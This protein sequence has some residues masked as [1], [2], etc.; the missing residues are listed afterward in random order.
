M[1]DPR[2]SSCS[3]FIRPFEGHVSRLANAPASLPV[4][5]QAHETSPEHLQPDLDSALS[6]LAPEWP[7]WPPK[8]VPPERVKILHRAMSGKGDDHEL[9][10][11]ERAAVKSMLRRAEE[12]RATRSRKR[13]M[14]PAFKF[15][16]N[17]GW[18]VVPEECSAIARALRSFA[19]GI[20]ARKMSELEVA[21]AQAQAKLL[22]KIPKSEVVVSGNAKLG[23]S[24][25]ELR[26]WVLQ[27]A[28]YNELAASHQGY[29]IW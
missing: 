5:N 1:I 28:A 18:L 8:D 21:Y 2:R 7:S 13:G 19:P 24:P 11:K 12:I 14:V 15:R 17:D 9:T 23:L 4:P 20:D 16:T 29:R 26:R 25:E 6:V 27:W 10:P 3:A 22:T